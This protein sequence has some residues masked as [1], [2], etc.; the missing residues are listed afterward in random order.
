M[1][2]TYIKLFI[3]VFLSCLWAYFVIEH[4]QGAED[5]ISSI[6]LAL[7]GLG[8]YHMTD[9]TPQTTELSLKPPVP[10]TT[11]VITPPTTPVVLV[12]SDPVGNTQ[13]GFASIGIILL[14]ASICVLCAAMTGCGA[15]NAYYGA[16]LNSGEANYT[17]AKKNI[18]AT[19]DLSFM[20]WADSACALHL[21]SL[22]RNATG[23]PGAV[24]AALIACPVPNVGVVRMDQ[25]TG[26]VNVTTTTTPSAPSP[27]PGYI[28][29]VIPSK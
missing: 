28:P 11:S 26:Q 13:G 25:T 9:Q 3:G 12:P 14:L 23:N 10:I 29:Q 4:V 2:S 8:V 1:N 21:G 20:T 27:T 24:A 15:M 7:M 5:I 22:Q 16:A 17:G 6:K 18:Q 19:D